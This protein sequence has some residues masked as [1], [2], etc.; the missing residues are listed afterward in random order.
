MEECGRRRTPQML[1]R[2]RLDYIE[3]SINRCV[4]K[5]SHRTIY[6]VSNSTMSAQKAEGL[7]LPHPL[8]AARVRLQAGWT[9]LVAGQNATG[10]C[11]I[12]FDIHAP[13]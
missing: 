8:S 6:C 7:G 9:V 3:A 13:V 4:D 12:Q 1:P 11:A 2:Y 10:G 5:T